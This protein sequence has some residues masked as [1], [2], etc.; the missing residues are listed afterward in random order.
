[1]K[2][3]SSSIKN[4]AASLAKAILLPLLLLM[5]FLSSA[6]AQTIPVAIPIEING[7]GGASPDAT[8]LT[9]WTGG[10]R[11]PQA[12]Y[13]H[14]AYQDNPDNWINDN[15]DAGST[16]YNPTPKTG[17]GILVVD[18]QELRTI[19]RFRVFQMFSDGKTRL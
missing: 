11:A 19:N 12:I 3:N 18:M 16:W 9:K 2:K 13:D 7:G 5:M 4:V 6:K 17:W 1:M 14:G 10:W 8:D 15:S